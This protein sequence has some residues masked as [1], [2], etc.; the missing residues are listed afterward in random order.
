M[1]LAQIVRKVIPFLMWFEGVKNEMTKGFYG[2][3]SW[4]QQLNR[5]HFPLFYWT[6]P[7]PFSGPI[8]TY[9]VSYTSSPIHGSYFGMSSA[10]ATISVG[11]SE[12]KEVTLTYPTIPSYTVPEGFS[13]IDV[14]LTA[15]FHLLY[16]KFYTFNASFS[17]H[18]VRFVISAIGTQTVIVPGT[19]I[20]TFRYK[21]TGQYGVMLSMVIRSYD[22]TEALKQNLLYTLHPLISVSL[23]F[24]VS[25]DVGVQ[26]T[27][28]PTSLV[29]SYSALLG[30]P[31][32]LT[33]NGGTTPTFGVSYRSGFSPT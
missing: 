7:T 8:P 4:F 15:G 22:L 33:D 3:N 17:I 26:F 30:N 21:A 28:F 5:I 29:A 2:G 12:V 16:P 14:Y 27:M 31:E 6:A 13:S 19:S 18:E 24:N 25:S 10:P 9:G 32:P 1:T 23:I 11:P 20:Q